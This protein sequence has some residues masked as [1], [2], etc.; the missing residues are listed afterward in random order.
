MDP[1]PTATPQ[2]LREQAL[3]RIHQEAF[4]DALSVADRLVEVEPEGS[5]GHMLRGIA[6]SQLDRAREA[7]EAFAE[8]LR[9]DPE[10][11][12]TL[13]NLAVHHARAGEVDK[14][15]ALAKRA[16]AADPY[17]QPT[18][19]LIAWARE[20]SFPSDGA[21]IREVRPEGDLPGET[22]E[23]LSAPISTDPDADLW[24]PASEAARTETTRSF[25][26]APPVIA[27]RSGLG[28]SWTVL[29]W[30]LVVLGFALQV[31]TYAPLMRLAREVAGDEKEA[32]FAE[33]YS[34]AQRM[35]DQVPDWVSVGMLGL[36]FLAFVSFAYVAIDVRDRKGSVGWTVALGLCAL[37]S[38]LC[39]FGSWLALPAYL[40]FGRGRR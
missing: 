28:P 21:P 26:P 19:D 29:G 18:H 37:V 14:V 5:S 35:A 1:S 36:I 10:N 15:S 32:S 12:R 25:S 13:Y 6:L 22:Q 23:G 30:G 39:G 27:R 11:H 34:K 40:L 8:A 16:L 38:C 4:E 24:P 2:E 17:H 9:L 33:I 7:E 20:A 3:E 31:A